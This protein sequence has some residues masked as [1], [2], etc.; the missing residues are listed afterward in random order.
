MED[1]ADLQERQL[2]EKDLEDDFIRLKIE[3]D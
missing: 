3:D 2:A 1:Y